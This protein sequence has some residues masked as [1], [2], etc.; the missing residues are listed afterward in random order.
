MSQLIVCVFLYLFFR[1]LPSII[2]QTT[3]VLGYRDV[4]LGIKK[5]H[6]LHYLSRLA[7]RWKLKQTAKENIQHR[8]FAGRHRPNY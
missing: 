7:K 3:F 8:G 1:S 5:N 4:Y 2:L 6:H